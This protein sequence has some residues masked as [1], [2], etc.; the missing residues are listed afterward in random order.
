MEKKT[1]WYTPEEK[2][3]EEDKTI[4]FCSKD[5]GWFM[6]MYNGIDFISY[7]DMASSWPYDPQYIKEWA[8]FDQTVS[9]SKALDVARDM[10][11]KKC[12]HIGILCCPSEDDAEA[13]E[14]NKNAFRHVGQI[15][16]EKVMEEII[17]GSK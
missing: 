6:G 8:Y 16:F 4:I 1:I 10:Y 11:L 17:K 12:E 13:L 5:G 2:L 3:P 9:A 15:E 7:P 14:R